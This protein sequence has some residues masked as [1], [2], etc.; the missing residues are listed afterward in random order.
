ML[1][2]TTFSRSIAPL[3]K[4]KSPQRESQGQTIVLSKIARRCL[5]VLNLRS[6]VIF[7][8]R[9]LIRQLIFL[10]M[11]M[12]LHFLKLTSFT[13]IAS[14]QLSL[15]SLESILN[16]I[17]IDHKF[18]IPVINTKLLNLFTLATTQHRT[19]PDTER[20]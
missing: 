15:L 14:V 12:V 8:M 3:P 1:E 2:R 6:R 5:N 11:K 13:T 18:D 7:V 9:F 10:H 16:Y 17:P 4:R 19:L 20:I